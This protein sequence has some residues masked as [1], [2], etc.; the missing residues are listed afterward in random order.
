MWDCCPVHHLVNNM[1][2]WTGLEQ[3]RQF[4]SV[5][6]VLPIAA[7]SAAA[8][9]FKRHSKAQQIQT[10]L[11]EWQLRWGEAKHAAFSQQETKEASAYKDNMFKVRQVLL[12]KNGSWRILA[13]QFPEGNPGVCDVDV[14]DCSRSLL[15]PLW[16]TPRLSFSH[17][18]MES[19]GDFLC[20]GSV[21]SA[22]DC[23]WNADKQWGIAEPCQ[24]YL[25]SVLV[26]HQH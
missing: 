14:S 8:C 10:F 23:V 12:L 9:L 26:N 1:V 5:C 6:R 20:C 15:A 21:Y 18:A 7:S 13:N 22:E 3:N 11:T 24:S 19:L 2:I 4:V 17:R 25:K 16:L